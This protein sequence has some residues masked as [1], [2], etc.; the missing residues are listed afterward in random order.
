MIDFETVPNSSL[1]PPLQQ[2]PFIVET[3]CHS[4]IMLKCS[5]TG[6]ACCFICLF[7]CIVN[8]QQSNA[9]SGIDAPSSIPYGQYASSAPSQ[10]REDS[11]G[12]WETQVWLTITNIL[13]LTRNWTTLVLAV[14][15][16]V[17]YRFGHVPGVKKSAASVGADTLQT[18]ML[19][20]PELRYGVVDRKKL[21]S[22]ITRAI[23]DNLSWTVM[24]YGNRGCGKSTM[25][26]LV[27]EGLA[28][29]ILVTI[30]TEKDVEDLNETL[31]SK[32]KIDQQGGTIRDLELAF[33]QFTAKNKRKPVLILSVEGLSSGAL[34]RSVLTVA[35]THGYDGGKLLDVV[36]DLSALFAA[37]SLTT[38]INNLRANPIYVE[39][40]E[41][42]DAIDFLEQALV[43]RT[44]VSKTEANT[45]AQEL[46]SVVGGNFAT[47][48]KF[49]LA[50]TKVD[51]DDIVDVARVRNQIALTIRTEMT[52]AE[53]NLQKFFS[54]LA[55]SIQSTANNLKILLVP[56][57]S[58]PNQLEDMAAM[59]S[60]INSDQSITINV[61]K[62]HVLDALKACADIYP[63][64]FFAEGGMQL[65]KPAVSSVVDRWHANMVNAG[66]VI[67][68]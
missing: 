49:I 38:S 66:T 33:T 20:G 48:E 29:V 24:I 61:T 57:L 8:A 34:L 4:R 42:A 26:K 59:L 46:L 44:D 64:T 18:L 30:R 3:I 67:P 47:L 22:K 15:A 54:T 6:V 51:E 28:G 41:G 45:L 40:V 7:G 10:E 39:D 52:S 16:V 32:L 56:R 68:T 37:H 12:F 63:L 9:P 2:P 27:F 19:Q 43:A 50:V 21:K 65:S 17:I 62:D 25:L 53:A 5:L 35:K 60:L 31:L 36:V 23:K 1:L 55:A 11:E 14:V 13:S 58:A